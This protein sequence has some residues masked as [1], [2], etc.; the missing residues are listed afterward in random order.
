MPAGPQI[1]RQRASARR[2]S[3]KDSSG[4]PSPKAGNG[5][6][7]GM[8]GEGGM[9]LQTTAQLSGWPSPLANKQSPQQ[10]GDFT[11]NLAN[12]AQLTGGWPTPNA[13]EPEG[14]KDNP[15]QVSPQFRKLKKTDIPT[16]LG[17]MVHWATGETSN[18]SPAPTGK[19]GQLNPEF[20]RWLMGYPEEWAS[21][22]PTGTR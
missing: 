3:G 20:T 18:G 9:D 12:V 21:C 7:P 8:H 13:M 15:G 19:R 5:T 4:W 16:N 11:P 2:T 10:R 6:G 1:C 17:R 14:P 22:A